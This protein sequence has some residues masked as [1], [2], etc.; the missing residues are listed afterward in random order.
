MWGGKDEGG[1]PNIKTPAF[2][3]LTSDLQAS[4]EYMKQIQVE[5]V[6][7]IEHNHWFV[8][9]DPDENLLMVCRE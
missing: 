3:F 5:L 2:M 9:K 7:E 6:T 4:F 8:I 1:P